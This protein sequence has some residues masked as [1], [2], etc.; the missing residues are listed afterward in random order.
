MSPVAAYTKMTDDDE[1]L[2]KF[3]GERLARRGSG[4]DFTVSGQELKIRLDREHL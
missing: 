3:A 2:R 1:S 4:G